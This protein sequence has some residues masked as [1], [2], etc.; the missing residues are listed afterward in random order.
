MRDIIYRVLP[1]IELADWLPPGK[2]GSPD[3]SCADE[4]SLDQEH[5]VD[6][7]FQSIVAGGSG[8]FAFL[9]G[10]GNFICMASLEPQGIPGE[11]ACLIYDYLSVLISD[12]VQ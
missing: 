12:H 7:D 3:L 1:L 6:I 9:L 5:S 11:L 2:G 4:V 10:K 8:G